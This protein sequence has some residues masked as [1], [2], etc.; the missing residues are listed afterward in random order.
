MRYNCSDVQK[1]L[2]A[3][4]RKR[5]QLRIL[6]FPIQVNCVFLRVV[7][8]ANKLIANMYEYETMI[9]KIHVCHSPVYLRVLRF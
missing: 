7:C 2:E 6:K 3:Q 8:I 9:H 5:I 4:T 1:N